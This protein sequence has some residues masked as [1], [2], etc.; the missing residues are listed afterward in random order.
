MF[1][2]MPGNVGSMTL[3]QDRVFHVLVISAQSTHHSDA[4]FGKSKS[5]VIQLPVDFE[6]FSDVGPVMEKS[7]IKKKGSSWYY[8]FRT[9]ASSPSLPPT[10]LQRKRQGNKL[11]EGL[12]VSLERILGAPKTTPS[13]DNTPINAPPVDPN[14][15][16]HVW[17]MVSFY[18]C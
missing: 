8:D 7:H 9:N 12:Y 17:D 1:H 18:V 15:N 4:S 13:M 14:N 11:T 6:S 10:A 5:F 16:H 3:L 2:K